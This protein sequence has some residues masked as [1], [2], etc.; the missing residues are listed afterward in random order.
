MS[1]QNSYHIKKQQCLEPIMAINGYAA[2]LDGCDLDVPVEVHIIC[3]KFIIVVGFFV[4]GLVI[5]WYIDSKKIKNVMH[6]I[7]VFAITLQHV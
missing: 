2:L 1:V 7:L 6:F 5:H 3:V 4:N